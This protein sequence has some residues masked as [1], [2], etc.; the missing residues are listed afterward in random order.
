EF[1]LKPYF[2]HNYEIFFAT[3]TKYFATNTRYF[4]ILG[5]LI[6]VSI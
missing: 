4:E 6:L 2:Y 3:N 5:V 1:N